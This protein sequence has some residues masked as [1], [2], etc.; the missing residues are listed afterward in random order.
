M[1]RPMCFSISAQNIPGFTRSA[2]ILPLLPLLLIGM[3]PTGAS[4]KTVIAQ[5]MCPAVGQTREKVI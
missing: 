5:R 4:G 3:F 2:F 1:T